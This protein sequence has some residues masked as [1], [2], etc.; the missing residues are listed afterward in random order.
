[1]NIDKIIDIT[2]KRGLIF[3]SAEIYGGISGEFDYGPLGTIM[4]NK[5]ENF[6]ENFF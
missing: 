1:M 2:K 6:G 4:K 3:Q 5:I